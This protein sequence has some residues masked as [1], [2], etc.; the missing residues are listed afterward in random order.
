M[1]RSMTQGTSTSSV[2]DVLMFSSS[3]SCGR[4]R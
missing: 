1:T 3:G 2:A 4:L